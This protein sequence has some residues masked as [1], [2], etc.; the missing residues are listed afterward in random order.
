MRGFEGF[1]D[2][3]CDGIEEVRGRIGVKSL[4]L[5]LLLLLIEVDEVEFVDGIGGGEIGVIG[6]VG[7]ERAGVGWGI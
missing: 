6:G 2:G 4:G 5:L 1:S 3:G 7:E